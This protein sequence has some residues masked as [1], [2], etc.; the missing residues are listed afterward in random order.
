MEVGKTY[1]KV[2]FQLSRE[3]K[4]RDSELIKMLYCFPMAADFD[5]LFREYVRTHQVKELAQADGLTIKKHHT[6]VP[7]WLLRLARLMGGER[8]LEF[9]RVKERATVKSEWKMGVAG[10]VD[11]D[12]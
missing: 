2:N 3:E 11:N 6:V 1:M 9:E 12:F 7:A 8:Y 4:V 10:K 5:G